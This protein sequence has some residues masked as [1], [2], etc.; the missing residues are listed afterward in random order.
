MNIPFRKFGGDF[1]GMMESL[2]HLEELGV[3]GIYFNP[4]FEAPTNEMM[5]PR[6]MKVSPTR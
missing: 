4:I 5:S 6:P 1:Q 3:T 2:D